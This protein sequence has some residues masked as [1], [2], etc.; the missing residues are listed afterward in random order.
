MLFE[1]F[2]EGTGC[3]DNPHNREIYRKVEALYYTAEGMTK[4]EAY[5]IATPYLNNEPSEEE[6]RTWAEVKSEAAALDWDVM[7]YTNE[8]ERYTEWAKDT[9]A[10]DERV[11][12]T[13]K[14]YREEA[15]RYR[16]IARDAKAR[17]SALR[18]WFPEAF[19]A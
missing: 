5:K 3:K 14:Y 8:A 18:R 2:R 19:K 16:E 12:W 4:A 7:H 15:K 13:A 17:A 6:R 10:H 11:G 9:T 1:E